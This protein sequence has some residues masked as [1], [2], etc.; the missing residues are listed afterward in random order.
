MLPLAITAAV[1][2]SQ[3]MG[4]GGFGCPS[5]AKVSQIVQPYFAFINSA[6]NSDSAADNAKNFRMV[7]RVKISPLIVMSLPS[8]VMD[9]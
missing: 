8:F 2:L 3:W 6:P 9:C 7:Q 5:Y 1:A 4:F